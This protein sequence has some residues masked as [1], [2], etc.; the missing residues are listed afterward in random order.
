MV[1]IFIHKKEL[2]NLMSQ[3]INVTDHHIYQMDLSVPNW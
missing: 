3:F 2:S 1:I